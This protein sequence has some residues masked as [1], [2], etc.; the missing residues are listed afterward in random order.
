MHVDMAVG[1]ALTGE[2]RLIKPTGQVTTGAGCAGVTSGQ[3]KGCSLPVIKVHL[4][5]CRS[6]SVGGM[7]RTAVDVDRERSVRARRLRVL[8]QTRPW[9]QNAQQERASSQD[10]VHD[11]AS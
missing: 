3:G 7:T 1:T 11:S 2:L 9:R 8:R 4:L 5:L 6:P 10:L